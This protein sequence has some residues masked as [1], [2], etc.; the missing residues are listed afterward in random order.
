MDLFKR[1]LS[2][3]VLCFS[4][5]GCYLS[6]ALSDPKDNIVIESVEILDINENILFNMLIEEVHNNFYVTNIFTPPSI[7][8]KIAV[9]YFY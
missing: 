6:I 2:Y 9:S 1:T 8:F 7:V 3:N 5:R 4:G